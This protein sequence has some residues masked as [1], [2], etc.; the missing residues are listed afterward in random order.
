MSFWDI[1]TAL[2]YSPILLHENTSRGRFSPNDDI[3]AA[4]T[5]CQKFCASFLVQELGS[6]AYL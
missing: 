2:F 5:T 4:R 6:D 3:I 1:V